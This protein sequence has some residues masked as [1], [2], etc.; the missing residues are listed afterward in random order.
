MLGN[1][2]GFSLIISSCDFCGLTRS[3]ILNDDV[4]STGFFQSGWSIVLQMKLREFVYTHLNRVTK[5]V[6]PRHDLHGRSFNHRVLV[7]NPRMDSWKHERS[8][9]E[10]LLVMLHF[11]VFRG[12]RL[13]SYQAMLLSPRDAVSEVVERSFGPPTAYCK[14]TRERRTNRVFS[15]TP[16]DR[17]FRLQTGGTHR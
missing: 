16:V 11:E 7:V 9:R 5:T 2:S 6:R 15:R 1:P 8:V 17:R 13:Q 3:R 14:N 12:T 4:I 10:S